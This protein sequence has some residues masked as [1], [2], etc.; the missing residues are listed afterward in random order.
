MKGYLVLIF[1]GYFVAL[2]RGDWVRVW[3]DDFDWNGGV[4]LDRW[5]FDEGGGGWGML[6]IFI[7]FFFSGINFLMKL[8]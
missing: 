1:V 6:S 7:R 2:S 8:R 5:D 3:A 4:A